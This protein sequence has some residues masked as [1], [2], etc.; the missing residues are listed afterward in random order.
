MKSTVFWDI[1][2]CSPLKF[3]QRTARKI[4]HFN[5]S[6]VTWIH[7]FLI[8][9]KL[10][11]KV[12]LLAKAKDFELDQ[13]R[14]SF[15]RTVAWPLPL[16]RHTLLASRPAAVQVLWYVVCVW[17]TNDLITSL[18]KHVSLKPSLTFTA[19]VGRFRRTAC[20]TNELK[21]PLRWNCNGCP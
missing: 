19:E 18:H 14:I 5:T 21:L 1:T 20:I 6:F 10:A 7:S 17:F 16:A 4:V 3:N 9:R 11:V 12:K 15:G 8:T 13:V 2:A